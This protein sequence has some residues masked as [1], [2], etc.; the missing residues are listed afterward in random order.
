MT[1]LMNT[2]LQTLSKAISIFTGIFIPYFSDVFV[3]LPNFSP[4]LPI[5]SYLRTLTSIPLS[6]S[7]LFLSSISLKIFEISS[8]RRISIVFIF[9]LF[10]IGNECK[11]VSGWGR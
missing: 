10:E 4:T 9:I 3:A 6:R 1:T 5:S 8:Q 11:S 2:L 7:I